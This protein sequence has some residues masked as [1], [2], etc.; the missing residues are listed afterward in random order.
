MT[1]KRRFLPHVLPPVRGAFRL[2]GLLALLLILHAAS[3]VRP[4]VAQASGEA[5]AVGAVRF[6]LHE[7]RTRL[8]VEVERGIAFTATALD[9]P[10][11]LVID[12]PEL[13]WQ[14]A[15]DG[16]PRG[17]V[18]GYRYGS[19]EQGR[20]RLVADL[21][22]PFRI[23]D[24][25]VLPPRDGSRMFRLVVDLAAAEPAR[26]AATASSGEPRPPRARPSMAT[27]PAPRPDSPP[28]TAPVPRRPVIVLD[29]GHGGIDPGTI[30]VT[31]VHE[32]E[33]TLRMARELADT[34]R[35]T[36]R[37]DVVLTRDGDIYI[38]LRERIALARE[39]GG[40]LFISL[41]ADSIADRS[42][43]GASVYT[44]SDK[45]SDSEAERLARKENKVDIIAGTDLSVHDPIVTSILIDLAQRDTNNKSIT[46]ADT[47]V[48]DL[49]AVTR[50]LR[51][52]RRFAGFA[53]L[54]SP[55]IPSVLLELGYLSNPDDARLLESPTYR[56]KL[57]RA[58]TAAIDRYFTALR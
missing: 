1:T 30:G 22:R 8:V 54:K 13:R 24:Q 39:A 16:Q 6:G 26:P 42:F 48:D 7:G 17:L 53:V 27:L 36:G 56:S 49:G 25:F 38:P 47:L 10:P 43:Q 32:K 45:A 57:A 5:P 35:A 19:I 29:A 58:I 20:S 50:L 12:L 4:V 40:T 41:H 52:T 11:R 14:V 44:L 46:F 28:I 21:S 37:Y 3:G 55:D 18:T 2:A 15:S 51:N 31:G 34:L 33:I 9:Q 23:T